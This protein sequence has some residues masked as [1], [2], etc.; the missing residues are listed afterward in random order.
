MLTARI[1]LGRVIRRPG[2]TRT[3]AVSLNGEVP[4]P[5]DDSEGVL[6]KVAEL[7]HLAEEALAREVEKGQEGSPPSCVTAGPPGTP[8]GTNQTREVNDNLARNTESATPRQ[9]RFMRG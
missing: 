8:D 1:R 9:L 2:E 7:F 5:P 3:Y 4:F 6:E